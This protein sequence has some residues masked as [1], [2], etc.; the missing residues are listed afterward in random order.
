MSHPTGEHHQRHSP[1]HDAPR[2]K[3][4]QHPP[5]IAIEMATTPAPQTSATYVI[6]TGPI[7]IASAVAKGGGTSKIG[8]DEGAVRD[9]TPRSKKKIWG[10]ISTF[11]MV[12]CAI[13]GAVVQLV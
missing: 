8:G 7:N 13:I 4:A 1:S 9:R 3:S 6:I 12:I 2:P 10:T 5:E 11:I